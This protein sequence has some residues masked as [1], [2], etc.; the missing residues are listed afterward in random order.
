[1]INPAT[2]RHS[3]GSAP[4]REESEPDA[5]PEEDPTPAAV[6]LPTFEGPVTDQLL[7]AMSRVLAGRLNRLLDSL[8]S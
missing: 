6:E 8:E 4:Y 7:D 2:V 3:S 1:M 5:S